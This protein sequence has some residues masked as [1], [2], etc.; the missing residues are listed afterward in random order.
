MEIQ[1]IINVLTAYRDGK[2]IQHSTI[3]YYTNTGMEE[4]SN[5]DSCVEEFNFSKY[6]YRVK[7]EPRTWHVRLCN[8]KP[9]SCVKTAACENSENHLI[10]VR[11]V[12][13]NE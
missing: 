6:H 12:L 2:R 1:D 8:G 3:E 10:L 11:E 9:C 4:W 5:C 7:P 13:D